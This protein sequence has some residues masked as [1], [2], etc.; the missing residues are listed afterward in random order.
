MALS[1]N[2]RK[3]ISFYQ[4]NKHLNFETVNLTFIDF[5]EKMSLHKLDISSFGD[6]LQKF[7]N[8]AKIKFYPL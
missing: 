8:L 4:Q 6:I 2:N 5:I 3:I 1:T 7:Q